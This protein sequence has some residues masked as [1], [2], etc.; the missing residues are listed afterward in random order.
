MVRH[1]LLLTAVL[2]M[3]LAGCASKPDTKQQEGNQQIMQLQAN[4]ERAYKMAMLDQAESLY[5]E[6]LASVPNYAPAW[7][8][9][10]NI[11]TR[12]G[13]HDAAI[14]AYSKNLEFQPD[15]QKAFYNISLV[16]IKQS[17]ET[18]AAATKHGDV[19]SPIGKQIQALLD[20]LNQLQ[21]EPNKSDQQTQAAL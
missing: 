21:R 20:A 8:R 5:F 14:A 10:G 3:G 19:N 1:L 9:L 6:V 17:T 13:R 16:R 4:A 15:N 11:Y 2:C 7:F 12:T 18:L